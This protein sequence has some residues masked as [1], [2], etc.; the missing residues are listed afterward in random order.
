MKKANKSKDRSYELLQAYEQTVRSCFSLQRAAGVTRWSSASMKRHGRFLLCRQAWGL[1]TCNEDGCS[2]FFSM[3]RPRAARPE[4]GPWSQWLTALCKKVSVC[5]TSNPGSE[6]GHTGSQ[7]GQRSCCDAR[8]KLFLLFPDSSHSSEIH[9]LQF[10]WQETT[11][12]FFSSPLCN[13]SI[14]QALYLKKHFSCIIHYK[15]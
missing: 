3:D 5:N 13:S 4:R 15:G 12:D 7:E 2:L 8:Q 10:N 11:S 14:Y 6:T 1:K 9:R